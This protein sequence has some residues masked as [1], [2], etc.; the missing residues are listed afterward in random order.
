MEQH[1]KKNVTK[2]PR[3]STKLTDFPLD[4]MERSLFEVLSSLGRDEGTRGVEKE[5]DE[6]GIGRMKVSHLPTPRVCARL[7]LAPA[8]IL[9]VPLN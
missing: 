3:K 6:R 1:L 9:N 7:F 5:R 2:R 8:A 4:R